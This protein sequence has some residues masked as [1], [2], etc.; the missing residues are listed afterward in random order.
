MPITLPVEAR[1]DDRSFEQIATRAERR[2]ARAGE[3]SG[4][5]FTKNL[6]DAASKSDPKVVERWTKAYDKVADS[7]GRVRV[8]EAKLADLRQ[9]GA[10]STRLISQS[11][12]L[13]RA[14]RAEA[15]ATRE[16]ADAYRDYERS[17]SSSSSGS[18]LFSGI[19]S[20]A[21]SAGQDAAD[22]FLSGF[23]AASALT[24]IA[25]A[26][27]PIG[28][29]L[30]GT[31]ALGLLA[32]RK[33]AEQIEIGLASLNMKDTFA[34]R[35]GVDDV[36][37]ARYGA[38]AGQAFANNWGAS[39]QENL[40]VV[41][42]AVQGG[43]IDADA[44]EADVQRII[45]QI[46]TVSAV[47]GED[48]QS[49]ARGVRNFIKTGMVDST[50][51]A[52]DL[53]VA[54]SQRGLN[55]SGDLLDTFE[56]YGT[57]FRDVGLSGQDALGL[58]NQMWE[59][60]IRNTD[61]AADALKEF[62][63][64]A[65]D[66][67]EST[68]DA[69]AAL[70][71]DADQLAA[72]FAEGGTTARA[73]FGEVLTALNSVSDPLQQE[74]IGTALFKT[75]WEDA[76]DAIK[77]AD[78][79]TAATDLGAMDGATQAATDKINE[80]A[81]SWGALG[82]QIDQ[83]FMGL[84][85]WLADTAIGRFFNQGLPQFLGSMLTSPQGPSGYTATYDGQ[86]VSPALPGADGAIA[87]PTTGAITGN[88]TML[89]NLVVGTPGIAAPPGLAGGLG[90]SAGVPLNRTT[91]VP[92]TPGGGGDAA[93]SGGG[94]TLP[95]PAEYGAP[96]RAGETDAQY[97]ARM[98][99]IAA[100]HNL[101]EAQARA[102]AAEA[103]DMV[104]A[105]NAVTDARMRA[106]ETAR[107]YQDSLVQ[108]PGGIGLPL[109]PG[110][111]A[112]PRPGQS[113]SEYS[114]E[115]SVM[116][117]QQKTAE[118]TAAY[119][120]LAA[121]GTATADQLTTAHNEVVEAQRNENEALL[122]LSE[123]YARSSSQAEKMG[124]KLGQI[125]EQ[126]DADLGISKGLA[127]I[128]ENITRFV[129]NLAFAP[130]VGALKGVQAANGGYDTESMGSGLSGM[131]G[132]AA[133]LGGQSTAQG[134]VSAPMIAMPSYIPIA[135][136]GAAMGA[137]MATAGGYAALGSP[138]GSVPSGMTGGSG[139]MGDAALL[140]NVPA[141]RYTQEERGDL[142]QGLADCTSAIEDL[143]NIMD[144]RPTGG[145][146]MSTANADKW[147]TS[148]GFQPSP[149]GQVVPGAFNVGF[150]DGPGNAGHMQA[151]LPGG[152]PFNWG[153]D[154]SAANRGIGGTGAA[155]PALT[156]RYYRPVGMTGGAPRSIGYTP[157]GGGYAPMSPGQLT[158]PGLFT[159]TPLGGGGGIS[160]GAVGPG[161][162]GG[163][164]QASPM[165]STVAGR[166][167]A[168]GRGGGF[169]GLGGLP[170]QGIN[171][172]ISAAGLGLDA[173]A[174]GAGQAA[175]AAA[176]VGI[177]LANRAAGY[178]GQVA[179]IA[180]GGLMETFLPNGSELADP[181][182]S[183]FGRIAGGIAGA[184]PA[185]PNMSGESPVAAPEQGQGGGQQGQQA[186]GGPQVNVTYNNNQ[187]T[188]DRAGKDLT[189]HLMAMNTGPG[190]G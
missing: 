161:M 121:T 58:I 144:G 32:G 103:D 33:L 65:V 162:T 94:I 157:M 69:F 85:E 17:A 160:T 49:I 128:A 159:P 21:Q 63:I 47:L 27:G 20:S 163:L 176:Q 81:S 76:G 168:G 5:A 136:P 67:S 55:I 36:A 125:G 110:Y 178:A 99:D 108:A 183:W 19:R 62:A 172:A 95:Y 181:A 122:R 145:A 7:A 117:A 109:A 15:R 116:E 51:E 31:A 8:E 114:A 119:E 23:G 38:A 148:R 83:T 86:Q 135:Y 42:F 57:K 48:S 171:T 6:E 66:G 129:A 88:G 126:L 164:P 167:P 175:S 56:E 87:P 44:T 18:G 89:E 97:R 166:A 70:G 169:A 139:Y 189:N 64:S 60:G 107:R 71:F 11:E 96:P 2:F 77:G 188:E 190:W 105:N 59:A 4:Q 120:R 90:A 106:D 54:A 26:T 29:A 24:R 80:H 112:G 102:A 153:S 101:A 74:I 30:A 16:A 14:R 133:G 156:R 152:T 50:E 130:M 142:T 150:W 185:L 82:R 45:E 25:A 137:P 46:Q 115:G 132:R 41:Q 78:L 182:N 1:A 165:S 79:A 131:I 3:Q 149:D 39:V 186:P 22:N 151:T 40:G 184:A 118:A 140:S 13:E 52:L 68:R 143:V 34:A 73:A 53:V 35:I 104:A 123:A 177:Q 187:A 37:M 173:L 12:S 179:G 158:N 84:R 92:M 61:V 127:G 124:D 170:M 111:A 174:P 28:I 147:L 75:K 43:L 9:S 155:D 141:G 134:A 180:A 98:A 100:Q 113:A 91:P 154:A 93:G 72:R 138:Y 146:S 10:N